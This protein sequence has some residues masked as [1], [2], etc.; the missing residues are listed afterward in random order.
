MGLP[1]CSLHIVSRRSWLFQGAKL[2]EPCFVFWY[3]VL[4]LRENFI[5]AYKIENV[6]AMRRSEIHYCHFSAKFQGFL[7]S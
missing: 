5:I 6:K 7:L 4:H 1:D 2:M 3:N